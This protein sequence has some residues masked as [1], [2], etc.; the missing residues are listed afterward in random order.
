MITL[1]HREE[2]KGGR[3]EKS[4]PLGNC[5][6]QRYFC[7]LILI[8]RMFTFAVIKINAV[9]WVMTAWPDGT[10]LWVR[11][12]NEV[13]GEREGSPPSIPPVNTCCEGQTVTFNSPWRTF[14]AFSKHLKGSESGNITSLHRWVCCLWPCCI[15][16]NIFLWCF[17]KLTVIASCEW[18]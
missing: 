5:V 7:A 10:A 6:L 1:K 13:V 16:I 8:I 17:G 12:T 3:D 2:G 9:K 11:G 18:Q 4:M 15:F 14:Y